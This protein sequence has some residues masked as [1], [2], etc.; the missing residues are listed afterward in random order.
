M[1]SRKAEDYL[2][3]ILNIID[4]Q[5]YVR[6]KNISAFLNV[7]PPSVVEMLKK[8]DQHGLV[9]YEKHNGVK[10]TEKGHEIAVAV[11]DK[12]N[13]I[14]SFLKI[15][16]VPDKIADRDACTIEH[17]LDPKTITQVK[18]L[19]EFVETS[20]TYPDWLKHFETFCETGKHVCEEKNHNKKN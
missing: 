20:P 9:R 8:L 5:G 12:H 10:L 15:I 1:L 17:G 11:V 19:V 2:E 14:K 13:A 3:A 6:V 18:A 16:R 4:E 7:K